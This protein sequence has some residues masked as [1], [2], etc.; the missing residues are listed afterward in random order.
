[1]HQ[2]DPCLLM[3]VL[4][5]CIRE[6]PPAVAKTYSCSIWRPM[7]SQCPAS[8]LSLA[9]AGNCSS[10]SFVLLKHEQFQQRLYCLVCALLMSLPCV[11]STLPLLLRAC[12]FCAC[13]C[14]RACSSSLAQQ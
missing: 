5:I 9:A 7:L 14:S 2:G 3:S 6:T 12:F 8:I 13:S 4:C 10:C 11:N 1:M